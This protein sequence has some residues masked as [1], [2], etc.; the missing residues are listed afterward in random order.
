MVGDVSEKKGTRNQG[1]YAK[2]QDCVENAY[3]V[4]GRET[5][6]KFPI[7]RKRSL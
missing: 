2:K 6:R 5:R 7:K 3:D 4:F 1:N